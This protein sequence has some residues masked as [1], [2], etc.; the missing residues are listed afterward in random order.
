MK[1]KMN[2]GIDPPVA[3]TGNRRTPVPLPGKSTRTPPKLH[4]DLVPSKS[5]LEIDEITGEKKSKKL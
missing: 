2:F 1:M 3:E 5:Q 4:D